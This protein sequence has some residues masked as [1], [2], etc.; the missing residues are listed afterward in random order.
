[1]DMRQLADLQQ[2][3]GA[4]F[5]RDAADLRQSVAAEARLNAAL[6]E[7]AA[8]QT[9]R[10]EALTGGLEIAFAQAGAAL[11]QGWAEARRRELLMALANQRAVT[12]A[13]KLRARA[14]FGCKSAL[15]ALRDRA[16]TTELEEA[17]RRELETLVDLEVH[18][19]WM[20]RP[21]G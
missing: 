14:S 16:T 15:E 20:T 12:E 7:I 18:K 11:W 3:A 10:A 13:I 2:V 1:M 6:A 8:S 9:K 21:G 17:N 5:D 19:R 4:Q